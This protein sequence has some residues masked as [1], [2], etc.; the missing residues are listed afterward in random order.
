MQPT[1]NNI[2]NF[3]HSLRYKGLSN[4]TLNATRSALPAFTM[5]EGYDVDKHPL[6][7]HC[8]KVNHNLKPTLPKYSFPWDVGIVLK[9]LSTLTNDSVFHL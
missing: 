8:I 4:S 7:C 3:L 9:Y 6:V 5:M 1:A 2:M